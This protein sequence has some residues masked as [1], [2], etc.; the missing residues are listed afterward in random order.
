MVITFLCNWIMD[1]TNLVRTC[2]D[3]A[4]SCSLILGFNRVKRL[5]AEGWGPLGA[6]GEDRQQGRQREVNAVAVVSVAARLK[7][8]GTG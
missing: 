4:F 6:V 8:V 2:L 1:K 5:E 7:L 3:P